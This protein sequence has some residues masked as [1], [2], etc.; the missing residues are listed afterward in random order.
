[1]AFQFPKLTI[2]TSSRRGA[3]APTLT[4]T[5]RFRTPADKTR[6][7]KAQASAVLARTT[8]STSP[9]Q[10]AINRLLQATPDQPIRIPIKFGT[11]EVEASKGTQ[12]ALFNNMLLLGVVGLGIALIVRR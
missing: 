7:D 12:E 9:V 11:V 1:M 2:P 10:G 6:W 8:G 4:R 3:I 5:P